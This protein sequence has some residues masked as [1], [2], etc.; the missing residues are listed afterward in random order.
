MLD[1]L[2]LGKSSWQRRDDANVI[3]NTANLHEIGAEIPADRRQVSV[4]ARCTSVPSQG[5]RFF[6]LKTM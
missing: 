1:E 6:V 5:S 4:H 3:G 2:S